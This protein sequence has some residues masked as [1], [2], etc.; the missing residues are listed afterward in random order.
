MDK[1]FGLT[2]MENYEHCGGGSIWVRIGWVEINGKKKPWFRKSFSYL[3]H[4]GKRNAVVLARAYRDKVVPIFERV[5]ETLK[6]GKKVPFYT[7]LQKNN[8]VGRTGVYI[9]DYVTLKRG[10]YC[11]YREAVATITVNKKR[12]EISRSC[13]KY[14]D[15]EAVRICIEWRERM[16][17]IF[18]NKGNRRLVLKKK[19]VKR[20]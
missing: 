3:K 12:Y 17:K 7:G 8:K 4:G 19:G 9:T 16:E 2:Y 18:R 14:G 5:R 10:Q 1:D 20:G 13:K 11:H 6:L 15:E